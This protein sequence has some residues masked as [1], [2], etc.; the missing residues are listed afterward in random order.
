MQPDALS[1]SA[2]STHNRLGHLVRKINLGHGKNIGIGVLDVSNNSFART[3]CLPTTHS[4][5]ASSPVAMYEEPGPNTITEDGMI[6]L[7]SHP[8]LKHLRELVV[9][10]NVLGDR[11]AV[12]L[13]C[14]GDNG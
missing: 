8:V 14:R 4:F 7:L 9:D 12:E 5:M 3:E 1:P 13:K 10:E 6:Q 11:L 2:K